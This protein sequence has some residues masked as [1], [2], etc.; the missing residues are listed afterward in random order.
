M[1][2]ASTRTKGDQRMDR[3]I[4]QDHSQKDAGKGDHRADRKIDAPRKD[5]EGHADGGYS[6]K[7]VVC[8]KVRDDP[9]RQHRRVLRRAQRIGQHESRDGDQKRQM[10]GADHCGL[11]FA[12]LMGSDGWGSAE[13]RKM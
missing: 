4:P 8:Q 10:S 3:G 11:S 2:I 9:C 6:K 12:S 13:A 7:G 5:H 1:V